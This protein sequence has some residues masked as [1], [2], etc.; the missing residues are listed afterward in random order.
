MKYISN[1]LLFSFFLIP[2]SARAEWNDC[3]VDISEGK[4]N[5]WRDTLI[6]KVLEGERQTVQS[7]I[8]NCFG[9]TPPACYADLL[10]YINPGPTTVDRPYDRSELTVTYDDLPPEFRVNGRVKIPDNIEELARQRGWKLLTYKTRST[11]GFNTP[12]NLL[13]ISISTPEK[14]IVLQTQLMPDA[15]LMTTTNNP[16]PHPGNGN[17]SVGQST[18][19]VITA[20]KRTFPPT[21][22][23]RIMRGSG[24]SGYEWNDSPQQC[25]GC[26]ASPFRP[27][28]PI[29][30]RHTN[31]D[32]IRMSPEQERTTDQINAVLSSY[33]TWG[34]RN[35][36]GRE[37]RLGQPLQAQPWGWAPANS[38]TRR[39][40]FLRSC[41][42]RLTNV[43]YRGFG[44]Y[45]ASLTMQNPPQ[46]NYSNLAKA[47]NCVECHNDRNRGR[48]TDRF[49]QD[50]I[51]FKIVV[52]Q[53]M[54]TNV[55]L[56]TD[57]RI[58]LY[59]CLREEFGQ[60]REAW[61]T[62]GDWMRPNSCRGNQ[63]ATPPTLPLGRNPQ[64]PANG[65]SSKTTA[66]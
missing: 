27:I 4:L 60:V 11:G 63:F 8:D 3:P 57:E 43:E 49:D 1:F 2:L 21:G 46:I 15:D 9:S 53:S 56:N 26:H 18:L 51:R 65:A 45:R 17:I 59:N 5:Q 13:I 29:G 10:Y 34:K 23:M 31:N 30:Y 6:S 19:T 54:P 48:L 47:M 35:F 52:D 44:A 25:Y 55:T 62:S 24:E 39:E 7:A 50:E 64:R 14:E 20:D 12:P 58:A 22:Q 40:E 42:T 16:V 37:V 41:A 66:Q 61:R 38:P 33:V 32:E 36:N 28:S